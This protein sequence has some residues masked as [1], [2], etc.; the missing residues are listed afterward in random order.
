[1]VGSKFS[2]ATRK[3]INVLKNPLASWMP[4]VARISVPICARIDPLDC[5]GPPLFCGRSRNPRP[6]GPINVDRILL[7]L[8]RQTGSVHCEG[9]YS[10]LLSYLKKLYVE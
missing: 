3:E 2:I 5:I 7:H 8:S 10:L 9:G 4:L 6:T 1:M